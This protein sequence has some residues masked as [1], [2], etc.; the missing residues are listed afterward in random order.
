M[1]YSLSLS[2]LYDRFMNDEIHALVL[3]EFP[4]M[5]TQNDLLNLLNR[6]KRILCDNE[7][8]SPLT[9][10][11]LNYY[12]NIQASRDKRY[13]SFTIKKKSGKL[14]TI[15]APM[16]GLKIFQTCLNEIFQT[17]Y[18]P[19]KA[20]CGFVI[21]RSIV[22]GAR[23]HVDKKFVLNIDLKDFFD[24]IEFYR[25]KS[26]FT[27]P[28]FNLK[29]KKN[30]GQSLP[31]VIANL[32]CNPKKVI[33]LGNNGN[34][35]VVTRSVL[36][37]GAPTSPVLTNLICRQL[38]KRLYGLAK[39]FRA[40]YTRY[41]DDITFSSNKNIFQENS[42]FRKELKR[43][44]EDQKFRINEEKTHVQSKKY[45]QEVTGLVVNKKM[46]VTKRYVKQLR[47]WLYLWEHYGYD[48]AY[49]YFLSD[50]LKDKGYIKP[51]SPIM[52][53]VIGGKLDYYRMVVGENNS[54]YQNLKSRF[55]KLMNK[56]DSSI[57]MNKKSTS[58]NKI[59]N[60]NSNDIVTI[61]QYLIDRL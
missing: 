36:P 45:R 49:S 22:D 29:D 7:K 2:I 17:Y 37:Q 60:V 18:E 42:E 43:I 1:W 32:C 57:S 40:T 3:K 35:T 10:R 33:R 38:D 27:Y 14:R 21:G 6:I 51:T 25:I 54:S 11:S 61:L 47:M 55:E 31:F 16:A 9:L 26:M 15:H 58:D 44:V 28:P 52:E 53:N 12:K 50:Y 8:C 19:N 41:A 34:E 13:R 46:N 56:N 5:E 23:Y 48:K 20:V 24:S 39:R 4:K 59:D 30:N